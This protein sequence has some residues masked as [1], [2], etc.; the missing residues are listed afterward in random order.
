LVNGCA[1]DM[2]SPSPCVSDCMCRSNNCSPWYAPGLC[3]P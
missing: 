2:P 1:A 3:A